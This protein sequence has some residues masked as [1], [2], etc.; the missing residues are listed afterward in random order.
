MGSGYVKGER[1]RGLFAL[2]KE[3][4][5]IYHCFCVGICIYR[6]YIAFMVLIFV[7]IIVL[8]MFIISSYPEETSHLQSG[9]DDLS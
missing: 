1:R 9:K 6:V 3:V 2:K 5:F 4:F 8:L 7:F